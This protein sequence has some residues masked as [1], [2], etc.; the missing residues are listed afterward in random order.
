M[1][2]RGVLWFGVVVLSYAGVTRIGRRMK[3]SIV[4]TSD[5]GGVALGDTLL[6]V[7]LA[8]VFTLLSR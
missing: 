5:I 4:G 2:M 3:G 7:A 1:V 6:T 8:A